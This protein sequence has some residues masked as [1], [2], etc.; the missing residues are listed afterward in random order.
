LIVD[1]ESSGENIAIA[2][3]L[4]DLRAVLPLAGSLGIA[5]DTASELDVATAVA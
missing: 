4:V 1:H 2:E 5:E 3:M